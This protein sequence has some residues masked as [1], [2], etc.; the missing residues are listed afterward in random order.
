[1]SQKTTKK[2][3]PTRRHCFQDVT[4]GSEEDTLIEGS[5]A[6]T[7]DRLK[8]WGTMRIDAAG[9]SGKTETEFVNEGIALLENMAKMTGVG[10]SQA[11]D[12]KVP[13]TL[14]LMI[15]ATAYLMASTYVG[16]TLKAGAPLRMRD[17]MDI[18]ETFMSSFTAITDMIAGGVREPSKPT[19]EA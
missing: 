5:L 15:D 4:E 2:T 13:L 14:D 18:L 8:D 10:M 1:M 11:T 19:V 3:A 9:D 6:V 17:I 12:G 16:G 7:V